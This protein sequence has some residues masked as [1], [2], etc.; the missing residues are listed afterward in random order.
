MRKVWGCGL[1]VR[2]ASRATLVAISFFLELGKREYSVKTRMEVIRKKWP[3][4]KISH[5][6]ELD[7]G[8]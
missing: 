8:F 4:V 5:H 1:T 6:Q 7:R 2:Q 3:W